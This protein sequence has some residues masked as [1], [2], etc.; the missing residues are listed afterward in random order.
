MATS[1]TSCHGE[2]K[3]T[4]TE[5]RVKE[6]LLATRKQNVVS[7]RA[8]WLHGNRT[9]CN[10]EL[11]GYTEAERRVTESLLPGYTEAERRVT[12]TLLATRKQNVVSR[13]AYWLHGSRTSCHGEL[14]GY[15]GGG[16]ASCH[17]IIWSF[18]Q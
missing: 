15:T 4:E 14:N 3:Y 1:R 18:A 7:R 10:G 13:R 5:R 17:G 11:T 9:S 12:E 8:Y 16:V 2:L 6:S